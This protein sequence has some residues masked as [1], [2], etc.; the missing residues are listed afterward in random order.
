MP[1]STIVDANV[2]LDILTADAVWAKWSVDEICKARTSGTLVINQIICAEVAPAFEFDWNAM[3]NWLCPSGIIL[4]PL[5]FEASPLAAAA[6]RTYR[7]RGG[8]KTAP[9][10]DFYIGAH[11]RFSGHQILTRD[12]S[13]YRSYF[14]SVFLRSPKN[15]IS[16][17]P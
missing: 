12:A 5:P 7:E 3:E 2:L 16:A 8:R 17:P 11:A 6:H 15:P 10:P 14:P 1:T 9:L 13:R 4:E